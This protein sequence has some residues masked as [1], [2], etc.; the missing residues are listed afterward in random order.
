M[1]VEIFCQF[2]LLFHKGSQ[3]IHLVYAYHSYC[4]NKC[5]HLS[6]VRVGNVDLAFG[7]EFEEEFDNLGGEFRQ[8]NC[9]KIEAPAKWIF[10]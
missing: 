2:A 10:L 6:N 5:T 7:D 8:Q 9:G 4:I 3:K 1:H